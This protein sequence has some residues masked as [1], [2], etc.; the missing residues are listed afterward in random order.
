MGAVEKGLAILIIFAVF[1]SQSSGQANSLTLRPAVG[2]SYF[3]LKY[4][5][6][7]FSGGGWYGNLERDRVN[8][9][10]GIMVKYSFKDN[11]GLTFGIDYLQTTPALQ[12]GGEGGTQWTLWSIPMTVGL[13]YELRFLS[14]GVLPVVGL[15]V[16]RYTASAKQE[17]RYAMIEIYPYPFP[18]AE[19]HSNGW[20][21]EGSLG[22]LAPVAKVASLYAGLRFRHSGEIGGLDYFEMN[23]AKK[24]T[25]F[26]LSG[27]DLRFGVDWV[28]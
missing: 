11:L 20:G 7:H 27:Y 25:S 14:I 23:G 22:I 3:P 12:F 4:M 15:G 13:E 19:K 6:E 9:S 26:Q 10:G 28:L 5:E 1:H 24:V 8:L 21:F 18:P 2:L 17:S 16:S